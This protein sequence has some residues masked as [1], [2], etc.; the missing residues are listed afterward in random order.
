MLRLNELKMVLGNCKISMARF[1]DPKNKY[2]Q[3]IVK[4]NW[5]GWNFST[6]EELL[7]YLDESGFF[8]KQFYEGFFQ[9]NY[10]LMRIRGPLF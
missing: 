2:R 1:K 6:Q 8:K 4:T 10:N 9:N 3:Y 5:F 7:R